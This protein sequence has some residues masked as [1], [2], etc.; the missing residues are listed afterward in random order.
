MAAVTGITGAVTSWAG[1]QNTQLIATGSEPSSFTLNFEGQ[2]FDTTTFSSAGVSS[3]IKGLS[4]W[5]GQIVQQ[6]KTPATGDLGLVTFSAGYAANLN[7]W[8][9]AV[10]VPALEV[11]AFGATVRSYIPGKLSWGGSFGGYLDGT[12]VATMVGNSNEPAT[13]T[14]KLREA[15]AVDD[16]LAG[17][18]FTTRADLNASPEAVNAVSYTFRG[19][20]NLTQSTPSAGTTVFPTG[21]V[22]RPTVG[23]LVLTAST[24]RTFTGDAFWTRVAISQ[25]VNQLV[26]VTI[27]FQGTGALTIG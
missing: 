26:T 23:S 15:G 22:A 17:S 9:M 20:G 1:A 6:L 8:D 14:F 10:D 5:S 3:F 16:T 2:E 7:A 24:G 18:I 12:T 11:T 25:V 4:A 19:S 13:G 27:D 21:V